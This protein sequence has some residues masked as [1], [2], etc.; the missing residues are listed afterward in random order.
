V[1][2]TRRGHDPLARRW[3][4]LVA[5]FR[6]YVRRYVRRHFGALRVQRSPAVPS[7]PVL[8]VM[9]HPSWWDPLVGLLLADRLGSRA[10]AV[11]WDAAALRRYALFSRMGA[12]PV[13]PGFE[14]V[15]TFLVAGRAVLARDDA[16]LWVTAQGR[17][18]DA[19]E[20]PPGLRPGVGHLACA[21]QRGVVL[22]LALEYAFWDEPRPQAFARFGEPI[23]A[24]DPG[25]APVDGT[26]SA[27]TARLEAALTE[28]QDALAMDVRA[29]DPSR[30]ERAL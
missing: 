19:R 13:G 9:N 25:R 1:S 21:M 15:A 24:R 23:A 20:R 26:A 17:F 14:G 8:V 11:P 30:F 4:L 5:L 6:T 10:H 3:P 27:W 22:P 12:F 28:T 18:A 29:R 7:G 2:A 16:A